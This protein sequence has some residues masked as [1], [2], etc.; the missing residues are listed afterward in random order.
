MLGDVAERVIKVTSKELKVHESKISLEAR[1]V[2]DL[3]AD[4]MS[5]LELIAAFEL[6]FDL[7]MDLDEATKAQTVGEAV[8]F[9][10]RR[11]KNK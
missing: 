6:E 1:F 2:E 10:K 7:D 11:L 3:G 8:E 9:I 4:S 5:S